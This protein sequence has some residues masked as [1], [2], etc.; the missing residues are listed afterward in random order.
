[1]PSLLPG[2]LPLPSG[3]PLLAILALPARAAGIS[4]S[5]RAQL[6]GRRGRTE[7][8]G[9]S[10]VSIGLAGERPAARARR[11][12]AAHHLRTKAQFDAAQKDADAQGAWAPD[13]KPCRPWPEAHLATTW[14]GDPSGGGEESAKLG[15][16]MRAFGCCQ[17]WQLC[18]VT[19]G[20]T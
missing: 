1:M 13:H 19:P 8:T 16:A 9:S 20:A 14:K 3:L 11:F 18:E 12:V 4:E 2:A 7:G 5:P 6:M 17:A 15:A 10:S